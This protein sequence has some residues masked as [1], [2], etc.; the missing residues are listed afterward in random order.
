MGAAGNAI[1]FDTDSTVNDDSNGTT[2][3]DLIRQFRGTS[4][5][6]NNDVYWHIQTGTVYQYQGTSSYTPNANLTFTNLN[7]NGGVLSLDAILDALEGDGSGLRFYGDNLQILDSNS[8]VR[9]R[10]GKL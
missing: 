5:V 10:L 1:V 8:N 9:V 3:A 4:E 7:S 6:L 2:K